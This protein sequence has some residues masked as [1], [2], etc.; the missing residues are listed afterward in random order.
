[1]NSALTQ[2]LEEAGKNGGAKI[3]LHLGTTPN[4][5]KDGGGFHGTVVLAV[6]FETVDTARR[7]HDLMLNELSHGHLT[8][9][10]SSKN[11]RDLLR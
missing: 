4:R 7:I 2:A 8:L 1:M 11:R 9:E 3:N 10:L 6:T 5:L